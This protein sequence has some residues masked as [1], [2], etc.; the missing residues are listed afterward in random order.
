MF[1]VIV[2]AGGLELSSHSK[3]L[4]QGPRGE[5]KERTGRSSAV[6]WYQRL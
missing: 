3:G 1:V 4:G 6:S 2:V 5:G